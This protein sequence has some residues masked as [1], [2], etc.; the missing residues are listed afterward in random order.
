MLFD[1]NFAALINC[2]SPGEGESYVEDRNNVKGV[3]FTT[4]EITTQDGSLR[5]M[6]HEN[7]KLESLESKWA[8]HSE[9]KLD[10]PVESYQL[11]RKEW[12]E[13]RERDVHL[14]NVPRPIGCPAMPKPP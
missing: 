8:K 10:H 6:P 9:V 14:G 2:P 3:I 5:N 7:Q 12:R 1:F 11:M 13:R 4:Y